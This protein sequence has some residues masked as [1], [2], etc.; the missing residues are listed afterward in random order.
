MQET[1]T[2]GVGWLW[3]RLITLDVQALIIN[4]VIGWVLSLVAWS[5]MV[6]LLQQGVRKIK[7]QKI[8]RNAFRCTSNFN[9][10]RP[11]AKANWFLSIHETESRKNETF[12]FLYK[13]STF[14]F[15][16]LS[17][18]DPCGRHLSHPHPSPF[19]STSLRT[20]PVQVAVDNLLPPCKMVV[21]KNLH[22]LPP[23]SP[24]T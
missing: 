18:G 11:V 4:D 13:R 7:Q 6:C 16:L 12:T 20:P 8:F 22:S 21:E 23:S 9:S 3:N 2:N 19:T 14:I 15:P 1:R 5:M 24:P 17:S 10:L